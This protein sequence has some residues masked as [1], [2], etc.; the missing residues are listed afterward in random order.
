MGGSGTFTW[1]GAKLAA[2]DYP[3]ATASNVVLESG[4]GWRADPLPGRSIAGTALVVRDNGDGTK[5]LLFRVISGG[6][7]VIVR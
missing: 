1:T 6:T 2:G 7:L 3:V 4:D 5:T